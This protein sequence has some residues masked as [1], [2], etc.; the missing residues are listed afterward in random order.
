MLTTR[1]YTSD[2]P[3]SRA[4]ALLSQPWYWNYVLGALTLCY[5]FNVIDRSQV[6]AASLQS[7]E[8]LAQA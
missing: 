7:T 6:L 4:P 8:R 3:A 1:A 2:E 5:V